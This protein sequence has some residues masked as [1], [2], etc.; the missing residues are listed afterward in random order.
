MGAPLVVLVGE[1]VEECLEFGDRGRLAGLGAERTVSPTDTSARQRPSQGLSETAS[2][3]S[4]E[5]CACSVCA[6]TERAGTS[7]AARLAASRE[8]EHEVGIDIACDGHAGVTQSFGDDRDV[9]ARGDHQARV[10]VSHPMQRHHWQVCLNAE[11]VE[12][13]GDVLQLQRLAILVGEHP[14]PWRVARPPRLGFGPL[15]TC[16]AS[17]A[18]TERSS[19]STCR[20]PAEVFDLRTVRS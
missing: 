14:G 19:R 11:P 17:S 10:H 3:M 4:E 2:S 1:E 9:G 18:P 20:R 5:H 6:P 7:A 12:Q 13:P 16:Q 15:A 8:A